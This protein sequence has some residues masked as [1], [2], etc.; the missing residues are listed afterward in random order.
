MTAQA[1]AT[2]SGRPSHGTPS[3]SSTG[4]CRVTVVAPDGRVDVALPEDIPVAD[5][6]PEI[7]RLSGQ[8]PAPGAPVG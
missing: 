8:S 7:L 5:L 6:Y 2:G 3:A 1:A 4:F